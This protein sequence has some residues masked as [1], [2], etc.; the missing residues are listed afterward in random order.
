MS[1]YRLTGE[2]LL[3]FIR[4]NP[5]GDRDALAL[6]AGYY[7]MRNGKPSVQRTEFLQALTEAHGTPVGRT[8]P[9]K[10]KKGKDP[11]YKIKVSPKGIAPIGPSYTSQIGVE[12]GQYVMVTIE[13]GGIYLEPANRN[14]NEQNSEVPSEAV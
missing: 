9:P 13:D 2:A 5:D 10:G 7:L 11:C 6:D 14:E 8:V 3:T 12:P 1:A 4:Q